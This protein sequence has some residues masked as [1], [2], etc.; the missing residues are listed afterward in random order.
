MTPQERAEEGVPDEVTRPEQIA[1]LAADLIEDE[2]VAGR[3]FVWW[4][5]REPT[6]VSL[7]DL[8]GD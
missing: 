6:A 8:P 5:G 1:R 2:S 4:T 7:E 3:V